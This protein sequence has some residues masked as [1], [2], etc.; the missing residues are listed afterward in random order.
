MLLVVVGGGSH[1]IRAIS[2]DVDSPRRAQGGG[3]VGNPVFVVVR[4]WS[5]RNGGG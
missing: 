2:A 3:A 1:K 5:F 4:G